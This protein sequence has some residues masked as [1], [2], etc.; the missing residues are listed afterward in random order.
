MDY[1]DPVLRAIPCPPTMVP[2]NAAALVKRAEA[3]GLR[4][5]CT[6]AIGYR[7]FGRVENEDYR[8]VRS[9]L[10][11]I[12][13]PK[14]RLAALWIGPVDGSKMQFDGAWIYRPGTGVEKLDSQ[15]VKLE[16]DAL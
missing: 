14:G 16:V 5:R 7:T 11:K 13:N 8:P 9:V 10:V 15:A 3:K 12:Q 2:R 1:P 6:I 4:N